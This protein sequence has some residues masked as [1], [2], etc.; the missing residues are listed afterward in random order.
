MLQEVWTNLDWA[1]CPFL[2]YTPSIYQSLDRSCVDM[3]PRYKCSWT[4][5]RQRSQRNV[6][7][8]KVKNNGVQNWF[9]HILILFFLAST[10][11]KTRV[12]PCPISKFDVGHV[13]AAFRM[14]F[15]VIYQDRFHEAWVRIEVAFLKFVDNDTG[16]WRSDLD[17]RV[18]DTVRWK[19]HIDFACPFAIRCVGSDSNFAQEGTS[20]MSNAK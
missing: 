7:I 16:R 14:L 9:L 13:S 3:R 11:S 5:L 8:R 18:D 10:S 12:I 19:W 20:R 1:I 2:Y 4:Q 6:H 15:N 17:L